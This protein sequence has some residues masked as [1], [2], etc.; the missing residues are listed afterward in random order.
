MKRAYVFHFLFLTLFITISSC[1]RFG[2]KKD[3]AA[4]T[5]DIVKEAPPPAALQVE[6]KPIEI[7]SVTLKDDNLK[8][9]GINL[10][11]V[12]SV[13]IVELNTNKNFPVKVESNSGS[14]MIL[15]GLN[16]AA[17]LTLGM[18]YSLTITNAYGD[19]TTTQVTF[20]VKD[21]SLTLAKLSI[22]G[23][24]SGDIIKFDGSK[25]ILAHTSTNLNCPD[26]KYV[27]GLGIDGGV[28]CKDLPSIP[29]PPPAVTPIIG[30]PNMLSSMSDTAFYSLFDALV[31]CNNLNE[32]GV[33]NWKLP[34]YGELANFIN[35]NQSSELIW[36]T[37]LDMTVGVG[38]PLKNYFASMRLNDGYYS[39]TTDSDGATKVRCVA[40]KAQN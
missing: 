1:S 13:S 6:S 35:I 25:W 34:S 7:S 37:N 21:G 20:N 38:G 3:L 16:S 17:N 8:V 22:A 26:G 2:V 18:I 10:D 28:I 32:Q 5:P 4:K 9:S 33:T 40:Y 23:A 36:T 14:E 12:Q 29:T 19:T 31:Y 11:Q 15:K 24:Q 39:V 30:R 27:S